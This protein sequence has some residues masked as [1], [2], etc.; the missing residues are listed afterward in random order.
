VTPVAV[1]AVGDLLQAHAGAGIELRIVPS[2]WPLHD[3]AMSGEFNFS[4][5]RMHNAEP[6]PRP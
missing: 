4:I 5:V 2:L 1:A 6:W 3:A